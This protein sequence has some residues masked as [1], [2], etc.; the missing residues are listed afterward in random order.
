MCRKAMTLPEFVAIPDKI[1]R[2]KSYLH[3][4]GSHEA[5]KV[6]PQIKAIQFFPELTI[7]YPSVQEAV[8][9]D[10]RA[11]RHLSLTP[12]LKHYADGFAH[13]HRKDEFFLMKP[14]TC[15]GCP[16]A[17]LPRT[18]THPVTSRTI[19]SQGPWPWPPDLVG[20]KMTRMLW[21]IIGSLPEMLKS[22]SSSSR[23]RNIR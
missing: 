20:L 10:L 15:L 12:F 9:A 17:S 21:K 7:H 5:Q 6:A 23:C 13:V 3:Y 11:V 18:C 8:K 1:T 2:I 19:I 22:K 16:T 14:V 4:L